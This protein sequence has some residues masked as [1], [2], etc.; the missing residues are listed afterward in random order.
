M[1]GGEEYIALLLMQV[2]DGLGRSGGRKLKVM[3][4]SEARVIRVRPY[5]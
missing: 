3:A 4:G 2:T 1:P 5:F